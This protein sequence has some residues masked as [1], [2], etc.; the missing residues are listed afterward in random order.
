MNKFVKT[1]L[2]FSAGAVFGGIAVIRKVLKSEVLCDNLA[3]VFAKSTI[4][5]IYSEDRA[6]KSD[7]TTATYANIVF[8]SL[9]EVYRVLDA[10]D[11]LIQKYGFATINDFYKSA[12]L[13]RKE[14]FE[15]DDQFGWTDVRTAKVTHVRG[16]YNIQFPLVVAVR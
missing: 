11:E 2:V 9:R 10:M 4:E 1:G 16:G 7:N 3:Q 13:D 14:H 12:N 15:V 5:S 8:S 6:A